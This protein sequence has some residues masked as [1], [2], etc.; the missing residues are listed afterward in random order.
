MK[1]KAGDRR[2]NKRQYKKFIKN[3]HEQGRLTQEERKLKNEVMKCI[4][5]SNT[6]IGKTLRSLSSF[7]FYY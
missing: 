6:E 1:K 2:M 3:L 5:N 4:L 7:L